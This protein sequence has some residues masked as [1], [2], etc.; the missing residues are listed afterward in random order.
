[1]QKQIILFIA[2]T[3]ALSAI[4]TPIHSYAGNGDDCY[5]DGYKD[6]QNEPFS[7]SAFDHCVDKQDGS[8]AY[9]EGFIDGRYRIT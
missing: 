5:D 9:Y 3:L 2:I 7:Q 1:M 6:G 4:L 8:N